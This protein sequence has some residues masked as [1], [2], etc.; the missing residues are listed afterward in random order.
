MEG[1][2]GEDI[3]YAELNREVDRELHEEEHKIENKIHETQEE[4]E[5]IK[6]EERKLYTQFNDEHPDITK[7]YIDALGDANMNSR[8]EEAHEAKKERIRPER[9][10]GNRRK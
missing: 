6:R 4:I 5:Q 8:H 9:R 1:L 3:N 7:E 2:E 10:Y